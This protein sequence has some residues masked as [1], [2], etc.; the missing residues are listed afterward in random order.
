MKLTE[1]AHIVQ[2]EIEGDNGIEIRRLAKIEDAGSGDLTFLANPK[3]TKFLATTNASAILVSRATDFKEFSER[4]TP[5]ALL[6]V[7]DPYAAFAKLI[8]VFHPPARMLP[9]GVHRSA[10]VPKS[11][12][13]GKDAAIGAHVVL[14]ERCRVGDGAVLW[15]GVVLGDDAEVGERSVIHPNVSIREQCK[16]GKRV[17]IHSGTV[18]GSDGF[19]FAPKEDGTYEK[20]PQR[21]IVEIEDDVEIGANCTIDRATIGETRIKRGAKLDNLIQVA[22]NVI[23]G[24][25]TVIA[26]QTGISG[27][28]K[29]GKN[30]VIAGQVGFVGHV[31][32]ADNTTIGAQ[33]GVHKSV[34]ESGKTFF[35]YPATE[36][37]ERLRIEAAIRELP[38]LLTTVRNLKNR[39]DAMFEQFKVK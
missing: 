26:A 12:T 27:S 21:G 6:R 13:I 5:I 33:S 16:V 11:A 4:K 36:L 2:G 25:N 18:V 1:I 31:E 19:G 14:G 37:R 22:H 35:G 39:I 38:E 34:K 28:T 15:H 24:E 3:Y 32:I 23:I 29:I 30:C 20:I 17:I 10:V 7:A 8:D 9:V